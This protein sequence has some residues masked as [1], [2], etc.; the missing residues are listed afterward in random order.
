MSLNGRCSYMGL[1]GTGIVVRLVVLAWLMCVTGV[2]EI[3]MHVVTDPLL[4][5]V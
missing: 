4:I 2:T 1:C 3:G 5:W